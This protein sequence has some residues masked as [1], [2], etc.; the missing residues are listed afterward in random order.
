MRY[1][2]LAVDDDPLVLKSLRRVLR[3]H[4]LTTTQGGREALD[5]LLHEQPFHVIL[6]DL[7]MPDLSGM[8]LY[9]RVLGARPEAASRFIFV[10]GGA[11]TPRAR[12]FFET[13]ATRRLEKPFRAPEL[14]NLVNVMLEPR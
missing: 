8:D 6:C 1:R 4:D 13:V 5:L 14:R 7:M 2:I 9:E 10:T 12:A 3:G 11:F